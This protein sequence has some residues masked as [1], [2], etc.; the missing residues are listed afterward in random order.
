M[1][2]PSISVI[3]LCV[4]ITDFPKSRPA[5]A[6]RSR[7]ATAQFKTPASISIENA[8]ANRHSV[9]S[10]RHP[11]LESIADNSSLKMAPQDFLPPGD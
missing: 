6:A 2:R 8:N 3:R 5:R 9:L 11:R 10:P 4:P 7:S 1:R